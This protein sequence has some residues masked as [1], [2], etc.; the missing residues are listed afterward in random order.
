MKKVIFYLLILTGISASAQT[1][2]DQTFSVIAF[3]DMP[4]FLPEDYTRFENLI[5]TV[6]T[7]HQAFN[8]HVGDIKSSSTKCTEEYYNKIYGYFEQFNK[9]LI[10]TPGDNEWTDCNKEEAG[11]YDPEERL[12]VIRKTFFKDNKSFGREKIG[13]VAQ[14]QNQQFSKFVENRRWEYNSISFATLHLVGTNNNLVPDSKN[15]NKE[16]FERDAANLAWLEEIFKN[17]KSNNSRGLVIFTQADMFNPDKGD[18]GFKHI[19]ASLKKLT[20]AFQKP[21]LW[22]NG[23][24]HKYIVD[25]PIVIDKTSKKV[26]QNFTRLQVFGEQDIHA[27]KIIFDPASESLFTTEQLLIKENQ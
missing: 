3:G 8:V 26:L 24:S 17:A 16:F 21:V 18:S 20:M 4:Y 19:L 22:V 6:N 1:K 13:L 2:K 15:F 27:V 7:Q 11:S 25:K 5:K 23:D 12:G 10:Y 14:S 9:P